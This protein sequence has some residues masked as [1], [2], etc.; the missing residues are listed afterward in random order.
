[1]AK[2][3]NH[4][5]KNQNHKNH[6]NGIKKPQRQKYG[7]LKGVNQK[8]LRNRRRCVRNDPNIKRSKAVEKRVQAFKKRN[9]A[10]SVFLLFGFYNFPYFIYPIYEANYILC[11]FDLPNSLS[12]KRD[13]NVAFCDRSVSRI[14]K[15]ITFKYDV[16]RLSLIF[17]LWFLNWVVAFP[18]WS[19]ALNCF[20][21]HWF[22]ILFRVIIFFLSFNFFNIFSILLVFNLTSIKIM[23]DRVII[24]P[25]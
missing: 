10:W 24:N 4:S 11:I 15:T 14:K 17:A 20:F 1:M 22:N 7:S 23:E 16:S 12:Q 6:Q 19:L 8:F 25:L 21:L 5:S 2:D 3:K 18:F 13:I 9:Q